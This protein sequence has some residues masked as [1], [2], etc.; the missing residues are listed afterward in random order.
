MIAMVSLS[1]GELSRPPPGIGSVK[2]G[3]VQPVDGCIHDTNEVIFRDIF[4]QIHWQAKLVHGLLN[5][6]RNRS[7]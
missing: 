7:F 2:E 6:Q 5:V 1:G 4:F 3:V